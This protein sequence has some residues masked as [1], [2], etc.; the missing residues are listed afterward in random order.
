MKKFL[1]LIAVLI[2]SIGPLSASP[3][4]HYDLVKAADKSDLAGIQKALAAGAN[5]N[6]KDV[7][8]GAIRARGDT[9][10]MKACE[11]GKLEIA[12]YL[13][14]RGANVHMRDNHGDSAF[15]YAAMG[16]DP[17]IVALLYKNGL[18]LADK[19]AFKDSRYT[20]S[21]KGERRG[22]IIRLLL[23]YGADP[24][25]TD[26]RQNNLLG[27]AAGYGDTAL[28]DDLLK[29]G[30]PVDMAGNSRETPL[31]IACEKGMYQA[32]ARLLER[33]AGVDARDRFKKT[34][35]MKA[36]G[37]GHVKLI[38]LLIDHGA[39]IEARDNWDNTPLMLARDLTTVAFLVSRGADVSAEA[40]GKT[41]LWGFSQQ[42]E[43]LDFLLSRGVDI[44]KRAANKETALMHAAGYGTPEAVAFLLSKGARVNDTDDNGST[45]LHKACQYG[46]T[47]ETVSILLRQKADVNLKNKKGVTPLMYASWTGK[48]DA[49]KLL[50]EHGADVAA[51]TAGSGLSRHEIAG[52]KQFENFIRHSRSYDMFF[53]ARVNALILAVFYRHR[54]CAALLIQYG[55]DPNH[56]LEHGVTPLMLAAALGQ[57]DMVTD[58]A[59]RGA[60]LTAQTDFDMTALTLAQQFSKFRTAEAIK[61]LL[62]GR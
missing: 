29:R 10:L 16:G 51:M 18:R 62:K 32:A 11:R 61:R 55:A 47:S 35:L 4:P 41:M 53:T 2:L 3:D 36:C 15:F 6:T 1:C 42:P 25:L 12:Q 46:R 21:A 23:S 40:K 38:G 52:V 30:L 33:G 8:Y 14:S 27:L 31:M 37:K 28:I 9:A 57:T 20:F 26:S 5:V 54:E 44:H 7:W 13:L 43:V 17:A 49:V 48:A 45:A 60:D 39:D 56:R 59:A 50:L 24:A 58:L 19:G 34:A 22:E